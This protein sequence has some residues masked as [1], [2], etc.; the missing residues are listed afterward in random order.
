MVPQHPKM[1]RCCALA[2][3]SALGLLRCACERDHTSGGVFDAFTAACR[4]RCI[5]PGNT[6]RNSC[7]P[8]AC[9]REFAAC[10]SNR[11]AYLLADAALR[12]AS[13]RAS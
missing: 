8:T 10:Q 11:W 2:G 4:E 7:T 13:R 5:K 6:A 9:K 1:F 3:R 12:A